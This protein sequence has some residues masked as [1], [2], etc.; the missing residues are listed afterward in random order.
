MRLRI[1]SFMAANASLAVKA[2]QW[3]TVVKSGRTHLMDAVPVT[4][5][6]EF[7]G[8]AR[9]IE[10]GIERVRGSLPRLGELAIGGTAGGTRSGVGVDR[11][12]GGLGSGDR[13]SLGSHAWLRPTKRRLVL[14]RKQERI[15]L[16]PP[17]MRRFTPR[18]WE[19]I[20]GHNSHDSEE[21][22]GKA[23]QGNDPS[24]PLYP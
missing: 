8:Y 17:L 14:V 4:L 18:P 19:E 23:H 10:A 3:R 2:T 6:Q 7:G 22:N 20:S 15:C 9:Q 16:G 11:V 24:P 1:S 13:R 21:N 12:G 5:G